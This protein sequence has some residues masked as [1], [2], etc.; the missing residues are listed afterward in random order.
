MAAQAHTTPEQAYATALADLARTIELQ[1]RLV[2]EAL[3][4]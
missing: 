1:R 3:G 4:C 2:E